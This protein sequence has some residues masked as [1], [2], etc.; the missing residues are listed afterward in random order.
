MRLFHLLNLQHISLWVFPTLGFILLLGL[1]LAFSHF[2]GKNS[3]SRKTEI[4]QRFPEGIE[5][6]RAPFPL[7]LALVIAGTLVWGLCYI[8][9]YGLLEVKI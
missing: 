3:E 6:R 8:L 4:F 5:E 9:G 7:G 1:F 2:S